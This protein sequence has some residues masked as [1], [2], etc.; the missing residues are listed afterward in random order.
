VTSPWIRPAVTL[1][2]LCTLSMLVLT[3][4]CADDAGAA[5]G[6]VTGVTV[7]EAVSLIEEREGDETFVI[8]DV[9][10]PDEYAKGAIGGAVNL[11]Y[12]DPDFRERAG[13]LDREKTYLVYCRTGVRS[14]GASLVMETL[15]FVRVHELEGGIEAWRAAGHPVFTPET[16]LPGA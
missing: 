6:V 4:G 1:I 5:E 2:L 13:M 7:S 14:S 11:D 15:G 16:D 9:R 3:C 8:L 12:S 10:R